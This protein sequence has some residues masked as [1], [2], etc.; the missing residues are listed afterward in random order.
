MM[1]KLEEYK[2]ALD[3]AIWDDHKWVIRAICDQSLPEEMIKEAL[4]NAMARCRYESA[5]YLWD[6]YKIK[7]DLTHNP[8]VSLVRNVF[9]NG[10]YRFVKLLLQME[11]KKSEVMT[12]YLNCYLDLTARSKEEIEKYLNA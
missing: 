12:Y 2:K 9:R 7:P 11:P 10:R 8:R 6:R 1:S 5:K 4:Y 3:D